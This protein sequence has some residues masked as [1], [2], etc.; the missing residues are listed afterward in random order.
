MTILMATHEMGFAR[1]VSDRVCFLDGGRVLEAGPPEQVL[2]E[3][4]RERT[5]QFLARVIAAG[6]L[7]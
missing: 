6:R 2:G 4:V 5:R 3:P 1:S 7:G